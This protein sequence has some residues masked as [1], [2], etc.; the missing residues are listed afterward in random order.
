MNYAQ[1]EKL[2]FF[3]GKFGKHYLKR[4]FYKYLQKDFDFE[5]RKKYLYKNDYY[6]GQYVVLN[7]SDEDVDIKIE[8]GD[9]TSDIDIIKSEN[10]EI[11]FSKDSL[12]P[13]GVGY[14]WGVLPD[15]PKENIPDILDYSDKAKLEKNSLR[16]FYIFIKSN[17]NTKPGIYKGNLNLKSNEE[18][19]TLPIEVE[20][21]DLEVDKNDFAINLWQ[22]PFTI[23]RYYGISD[24]E[25]FKEKHLEILREHL[26]VYKSIGGNS[27]TTTIEDDPWYQQTY[28]KY[29]SMV[30]EIIKD[31]KV[32]YDFSYFDAYVDLAIEEGIDGGIM[33][34]SLADWYENDRKD[35][36]LVLGLKPGSKE[37][38]EYWNRFLEIFI[39]H[40]D[41]KG[42]FEKTYIAVDERSPE[43]LE[44]VLKVLSKHKN[45]DGK[46]LKIA[47]QLGYKKEFVH[48]YDKIDD[49]SFGFI[50]ID[51]DNEAYIKKRGDKLTTMYT[52]TGMYPNSF[53]RSMP[54]ESDWT[55]L[56][57][58]AIKAKG[59]LR[60][61]LDAWVKD[62]LEDV[63]HWWWEGGDPFLIYPADKDAENKRP[64]TS[65]RFEHLR[66]ARS[67]VGKINYLAKNLDD[68]D[69]KEFLAIVRSMKQKPYISTDMGVKE[70]DIGVKNAL[71]DEVINIYNAIYDYSKRLDL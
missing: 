65:P 24:D 42:Y 59:Y 51:A 26:R 25:L 8:V 48:I 54:I 57:A 46:T 50:D 28:D 33:A 4:E 30:K 60:W 12:C 15:F 13:I 20:V 27:I 40:L 62:P 32:D 49:I 3:E 36:G 2:I 43:I 31:G 14:Q 61:A 67:M 35:E 39:D 47:S 63:S 41:S 22:Y 29:P 56:Y 18:N 71:Y 66:Y 1:N 53:A 10:I 38:E 68:E 58:N 19:L 21:I 70:A 64:R 37:W 17:P 34:F 5:D 7:K 6:M 9:L 45:K 69:K 44:A 23:A 11:R 55:I 52:C 16:G